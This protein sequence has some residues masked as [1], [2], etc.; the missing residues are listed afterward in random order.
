MSYTMKENDAYGLASSLGASTRQNGRELNFRKCPYCQGGE[1]NDQYTFSVNLDTGA[2]CCQR[3]KCGMKGHFVELARDF[4]YQLEFENDFQPKKNYKKMP[5]VM[6]EVRSSAV[7]YLKSRGISQAV[8]ERYHIT[9]R[10]DNDKILVFP[11]YD[12]QGQLTCAKYR[13]TDFK[14]GVHQ[15]KEWFEKDTRPI[16]FGMKQ[17]NDF[18]KPLIIT[19]GQLDSLSVAEAGFENAVSVPNGAKGFTW[20]QFCYEWVMKFPKLIVFGDWERGKMSLLDELKARF[21][22][23]PIYAVRESD[24]LGEKDANDILKKYRAQAV[25]TAVENAQELK[26]E[27]IISLSEVKREDISEREH[28]FTNIYGID[29][30]IGGIFAG[31]L[32]AL[33]GRRGEGKSTFGSQI[34][35]EAVEQGWNVF[36]YSGELDA[37]LFK[38]WVDMQMTHGQLPRYPD[39][40]GGERGHFDKH[41]REALDAWY[42]NRV[43]LFDNRSAF[44]GDENEGRSETE[45]VLAAVEEAVQRLDVKLIIIDNLMTAVDVSRAGELMQA[46]KEFVKK[47]KRTAMRYNVAVLLVAHP[48]KTDAKTL[49]N[50]DISGSADITNLADV[51]LI[52]AKADKGGTNGAA[53]DSAVTVLKNRLNGRTNKDNPVYVYFDPESKFISES[54]A[55]KRTYSYDKFDWS[56]YNPSDGIPF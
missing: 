50:D 23:L 55:C 37:A 29:K 19:E 41:T 25:R 48:R 31:Q 5:Q 1:S 44:F 35:C 56:K 34:L 15:S 38:H 49:D 3:V 27:N 33:T 6:P 42:G 22:K 21:P 53:Y 24:Y 46:Q 28:I 36:A 2:F 9:V 51:V 32:I 10:K 40:T 16:L 52:Y 47:L 12:E 14:K 7:E 4:H 11:F 18:T 20:V 17:A 54:K 39:D 13:Q 26:P 30:L 8:A 43:Y 45:L